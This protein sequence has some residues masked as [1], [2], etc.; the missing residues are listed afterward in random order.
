MDRVVAGLPTAGGYMVCGR[1]ATRKASSDGRAVCGYHGDV[2]KKALAR[3]HEGKRSRYNQL[4]LEQAGR[5]RLE[6]AA[7]DLLEACQ[8]ALAFMVPLEASHSVF[9]APIA[10]LRAAI[11]KTS[12]GVEVA[13]P[14]EHKPVG[15]PEDVAAALVR[16]LQ[17]DDIMI[18]RLWPD[19]TKDVVAAVAEALRTARMDGINALRAENVKLRSTLEEIIAGR[20]PTMVTP[21][22]W[23][24]PVCSDGSRFATAGSIEHDEDCLYDFARRALSGA[25]SPEVPDAVELKAD[26]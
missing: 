4:H 21:G 24:C 15:A 3:Q 18:R 5:W 23:Y 8:E 11:A 25:T 26:A 19:G 9:E 10:S 17:R 12:V 1:P 2:K 16:H 6:A 13:G 20:E 14:Q 22:Q 7:P